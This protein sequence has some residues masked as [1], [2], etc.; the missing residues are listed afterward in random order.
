MSR[1]AAPFGDRVDRR[2]P[3]ECWP[4]TGA[5][6][7]G[8]G[9]LSR[10]GRMV[11]AHRVA[12]ELSSGPI[13]S[14]LEVCHTCDNPLCCNPTHLWLGTHQQNMADMGRKRRHTIRHQKLTDAQVL[15]LRARAA[16]GEKAVALAAAYGIKRVTVYNIVNGN[17]RLNAGFPQHTGAPS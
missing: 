15:Q 7:S 11:Y 16:G 10:A 1:R 2:G 6:T 5:T 17:S 12:F 9:R 8:Y 4:W 13:P 14:G 3:D